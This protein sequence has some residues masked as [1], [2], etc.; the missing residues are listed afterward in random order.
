MAN[1]PTWSNVKLRL[2][3]NGAD[4]ST[5]ITDVSAS[6]LTFTAVGNAQLDTA[7]KKYG[8]AAL[9]L[10]GTGDSIRA[11]STTGL[12]LPGDFTLEQW[13]YFVDATPADFESIFYGNNTADVLGVVRDTSGLLALVID[14]STP[15]VSGSAVSS[16]T[17]H[18]IAVERVG[19]TVKLYLNGTS[20]GSYTSSATY[21]L[22][23]LFFGA[24]DYSASTYPLKGSID[25]VRWTIGEAVYGADF[26]P[27]ASEMPTSAPM[28]A[29]TSLVEVPS[30]LGTPQAFGALVVGQMIEPGPLMAV[31]VLGLHDFSAVLGSLVTTY[32]CDLVTPSGTV[33]VPISSWQATLRAGAK[34]YVQCVIPACTDLVD[35]VTAATEFA[36]YRRA[37]LASGQVIEYEMAR[38][39]AQTRA[40]DQGPTNHTCT[41][42]GYADGLPKQTDP[43]ASYDRTLTGIRSQHTGAGGARIRCAID[44]FLRP[45]QRAFY[46]T[47]PFIVS[48]INYY[49]PGFDQYMD[50]GE[51][52]A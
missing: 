19:S 47:T 26:T 1:P 50:V 24:W 46:G 11:D 10:D 44:W 39:P 37:T 21:T 31:S 17:W 28:A 14:L 49:V 22:T 32:V 13:V 43:P 15:I 16:G 45:G 3:L 36:I 20:L 9:L 52:L 7:I 5:A 8:S 12:V 23:E 42:S 4:A 51:E 40:F 27:P 18:H 35:E 48:Y 29:V 34:S 41:L 6:A 38:A 25:D 30:M 33:R 2:P